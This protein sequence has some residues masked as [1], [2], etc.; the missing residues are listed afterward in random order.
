MVFNYSNHKAVKYC[1]L[2]N[3]K[4][5]HHKCEAFLCS[6]EF[7]PIVFTHGFGT[8]FCSQRYFCNLSVVNLLGLE[9]AWG[10]GDRIIKVG[11]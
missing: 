5:N 1:A 6:V 8:L 4:S 7:S 3:H 2:I 11:V 9:E 10:G